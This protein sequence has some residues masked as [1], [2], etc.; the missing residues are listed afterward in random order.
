[1]LRVPGRNLSTKFGS[2]R[3][4][5]LRCGYLRNDPRRIGIDNLGRMD[6]RLLCDGIVDC[7]H[8]LRGGLLRAY[9]ELRFMLSLSHGLVLCGDGSRGGDGAVLFGKILRLICEH[10]LELFGGHVPIEHELKRMLIVPR[11]ILLLDEWPLRK[12][13]MPSW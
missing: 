2:G 8:K 3:M 11:W 10:V 9:L 12:V 1:M 4:R 13:A 5:R 7:M 6:A